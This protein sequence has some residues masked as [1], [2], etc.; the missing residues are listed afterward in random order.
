M[1][2][3]SCRHIRH[4]PPQAYCPFCE[5]PVSY[6]AAHFALECLRLWVAVAFAFRSLLLELTTMGLPVVQE[7]VHAARVTMGSRSLSVCVAP[8]RDLRADPRVLNVTM[9]RPVSVCLEFAYC[10]ALVPLDPLALVY[11]RAL[12]SATVTEDLGLLLEAGQAHGWSCCPS[13]RWSER[14]FLTC[15]SA[16][17]GAGC[18]EPGVRLPPWVD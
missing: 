8:D 16:C 3:R 2:V 9:S 5:R 6:C 4:P 11:I 17:T 1:W 18:S 15:L 14:V 12:H 13:L 7:T 10:V